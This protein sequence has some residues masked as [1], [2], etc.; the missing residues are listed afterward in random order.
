MT[1]RD[2]N[3]NSLLS[4][5]SNDIIKQCSQANFGLYDVLPMGISK[6]MGEACDKFF[7]SRNIKY[8]SSW[9]YGFTKEKKERKR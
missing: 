5:A 9:F 8:G 2:K 4:T 3:N 6:D 7:K 1:Y